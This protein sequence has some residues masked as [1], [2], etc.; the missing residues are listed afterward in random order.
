MPELDA[1]KKHSTLLVLYIPSA[2]RFGKSLGTKQQDRWVRKA[3]KVL[4]Q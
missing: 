4:G 3:L 1:F 2:D